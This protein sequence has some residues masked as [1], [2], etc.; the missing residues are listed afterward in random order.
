[1][2]ARS[3]FSFILFIITLSGCS[4]NSLM[5]PDCHSCTVEEQEWKDFSW[6]SL[7]GRWKGNVENM[8]T[9]QN[10][11]LVRTEKSVEL[12]FLTAQE[13]LSK[14]GGSCASLPGNAVV[15]NGQLWENGSS[16][17]VY[18]A[19]VPAEDGKVAYGRVSFDKMNGKEM[20]HFRGFG[21]VMGKNRL[22]LPSIAFS[23]N[24]LLKDRNP[25]SL[26]SEQEINV[27]FLRFAKKDKPETSFRKD[28]RAPSSVKEQERPTLILRVF[29]VSTVKN[30]KRGEWKGTDEYIYR[31]WK[32]N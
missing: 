1:M 2:R 32:T 22:N 29:K 16:D 9:K 10:T 11:P 27:E 24:V 31:L 7:G 19:F 5:K 6:A 20:C 28:G 17:K 3:L 30:G 23:D 13:F 26:T 18:E 8:R 21:R 12:T 15:M 25:A 4:S 14:V